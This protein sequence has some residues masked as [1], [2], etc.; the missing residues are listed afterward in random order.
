MNQGNLLANYRENFVAITGEKEENS[1]Y[2]LAAVSLNYS[3][4]N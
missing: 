1:S 2:E 4:S 3:V